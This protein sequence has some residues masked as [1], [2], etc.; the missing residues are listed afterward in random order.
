MILLA[1]SVY[2]FTSHHYLKI[3]KIIMV[4]EEFPRAV[5]EALNA[6]KWWPLSSVEQRAQ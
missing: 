6:C 1:L 4:P 3:N 2:S 5:K